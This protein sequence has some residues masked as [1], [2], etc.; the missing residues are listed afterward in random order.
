[1][2]SLSVDDYET[3][4]FA[5]WRRSG[6]Y[7]YRPDLHRSCCQAHVIRLHAVDYKPSST[8]RR[9][10]K[11]LRRATAPAPFPAPT[12]APTPESTPSLSTVTFQRRASSVTSSGDACALFCVEVKRAV[13]EALRLFLA[14]AK[15]SD[16]D[17]SNFESTIVED[18]CAS[19]KVM[20]RP[21]A[22]ASER[23]EGGKKQKRRRK[24]SSNA[25]APPGSGIV[26]DGGCA[27]RGAAEA[28]GSLN[29]VVFASNIA[30]VAAGLERKRLAELRNGK[31]SERQMLIAEGVAAELK[32]LGGFVE[33]AEVF[34][35]APG[36]INVSI[37]RS[38]LPQ[39]ASFQDEPEKHARLSEAE[40]RVAFME[41]AENVAVASVVEDAIASGA[42]VEENVAEKDVASS[43]TP[44]SG[45]NT[46]GGVDSD[47]EDEWSSESDE[48]E[49]SPFKRDHSQNER[50]P[51]SGKAD[52]EPIPEGR[53]F[54]MVL[55]PSR[56]EEDEYRIYRAYQM[57]VHKS[58]E[59]ECKERSYRRFLVDSPLRAVQK[60]GGPPQGYGSF[61]IRYSLGDRLFAVGVVDVLPQ[62]LSSVYLFFDP[63]YSSLSPGVLSAVKEI[64]W[65]Q[66]AVRSTSRLK[67]YVMGYYIHTCPKMAY[68]AGF[69]P[70]DI[71]CEET[72]HWVPASTATVILSAAEASGTRTIRIAPN[73][74]TA[75]AA[76]AQH[77]NSSA[78]LER[79][80]S[81]TVMEFQ[82]E[83]L[84]PFREIERVFGDQLGEVVAELRKNLARFTTLVG[85]DLS[86]KFK[87]RLR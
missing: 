4:V 2:H 87:H 59:S 20:V 72:R 27:S 73:S 62:C 71:L 50:L 6:Q 10:L 15:G 37:D 5:G 58:R 32:V 68:K 19:F 66:E 9:V 70:S 49:E 18:A 76:A 55:V 77:R 11:R 40:S 1:M 38:L 74:L 36:W 14:K 85:T 52:I 7:L 31:T 23:K 22:K 26:F 47:D 12:Q 16:S 81:D 57:A 41:V 54:S 44:M 17:G 75:A 8:H 13:G 46:D 79:L 80:V 25:L 63:A 83:T 60:S 39:Q 53:L 3:M 43:E 67:Y 82:G 33:Q 65:V 51:P 29:S 84:V 24:A 35:A 45:T 86:E 78:S 34:C 69:K 56:F 30:M 61:H 21:D 48:D 42:S 64:E 28:H